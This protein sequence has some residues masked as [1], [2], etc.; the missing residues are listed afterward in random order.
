MVGSIVYATN[1]GLGVLAKSFFDN[2]LIDK[3]LIKPHSTYKNHYDWYYSASV[4]NEDALLNRLTHLIIFET[5]FDWKIILKAREL[6]IKVIL[7]PMYE[8]TRFP[9]VY[10][11]DEIWCPSKLDYDFYK[12]KGKENIKLIQIPVDIKWKKRT[13]ALTFVH[14]AGNGGLGGRNGTLELIKAMEYVKSPIKLIIRTQTIDFKCEDPRVEIRFGTTPYESLW[15]EGDVF[16][17][18][19]KFNGLSLPIQEAYASGMLV[20]T[21]NRFPNNTYLP[22][23]PLI[24]VN[25]Y[26]KERIAVEFDMADI[27][28]QDIASTIDLWYNKDITKYSLLGK[29]WG[30]KNSWKNLKQTYKT[31][32]TTTKQEK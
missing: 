25:S 18:P 11:P 22:N 24:K 26:H 17:F 27:L 21:T 31:L 5:P 6:G 8:C 10:E 2:G 1:Q 12:S 4:T 23:E 32:F 29:E 30:E 13:R 9:F 15:K 7:I 28:P 3:V 14:N 16:I 20:M 19:E